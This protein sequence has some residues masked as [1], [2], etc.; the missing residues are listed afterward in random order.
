M[1]LIK[2]FG[3][4]AGIVGVMA[5]ISG[6]QAL[7]HYQDVDVFYDGGGA[8]FTLVLQQDGYGDAQNIIWNDINTTCVSGVTGGDWGDVGSSTDAYNSTL[9]VSYITN[10]GTAP[11][12]ATIDCVRDEILDD[13][14]VN[15]DNESLICNDPNTANDC[16]DPDGG[17]MGTYKI[18]TAESD[19][20]QLFAAGDGGGSNVRARTTAF[21]VGIRDWYYED[22]NAGTGSGC[23]ATAGKRCIGSAASG[24]NTGIY[25]V[26]CGAMRNDSTWLAAV[27]QSEGQTFAWARICP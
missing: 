20:Y 17:G 27:G 5:V 12:N 2:R 15:N 24:G 6:C 1:K 19:A 7:R 13:P 21:I 23:L 16:Q 4:I 18:E 22:A 8:V 10:F 11:S 25:A 14:N 26:N 3:V 9:D